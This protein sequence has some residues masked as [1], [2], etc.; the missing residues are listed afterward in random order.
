[1]LCVNK[2]SLNI[3]SAVLFVVIADSL[4]YRYVHGFS[5]LLSSDKIPLFCIVLVK[6]WQSDSE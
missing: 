4:L 3:L 1:M 6:N 5:C 2:Y